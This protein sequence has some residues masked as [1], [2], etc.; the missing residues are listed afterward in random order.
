MLVTTQTTMQIDGPGPPAP[1]LEGVAQGL[2]FSQVSRCWVVGPQTCIV[3]PPSPRPSPAHL[4]K[5]ED[6]SGFLPGAPLLRCPSAPSL[7]R[8]LCIVGGRELVHMRF[9]VLGSVLWSCG[10]AH[11]RCR[12]SGMSHLPALREDRI[13][14]LLAVLSHSAGLPPLL[15]SYMFSYFLL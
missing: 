4:V 2:M 1:W 5:W 10:Y 7:G 3:H 8:P 14:D 13:P 12:T 6:N 11:V 15:S 9:S